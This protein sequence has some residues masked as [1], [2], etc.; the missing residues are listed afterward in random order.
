[1][2]AKKKKGKR[3]ELYLVDG[4]SSGAIE[5]D[6]VNSNFKLVSL[7]NDKIKDYHKDD[8]GRGFYLLVQ[9]NSNVDKPFSVYV[10]ESK[11]VL[12]RTVQHQAD[13]NKEFE[14]IILAYTSDDAL[15]TNLTQYI[16]EKLIKFC[17]EHPLVNCTNK[18]KG[19]AS[20]LK[21][22]DEDTCEEL[23]E[24]F[25]LVLSALGYYFI[26][27]WELEPHELK[28][29]YATMPVVTAPEIAEAPFVKILPTLESTDTEHETDFDFNQFPIFEYHFPSRKFT[30]RT[31]WVA[32]MKITGVDSFVL[33]KGSYVEGNEEYRF[34]NKY[35]DFS[36]NTFLNSKKMYF[37]PIE[38][39]DFLNDQKCYVTK[40]D[41]TYFAPS[42][43]I[44]IAQG[45]S[46]NGWI[47]WKTADGETL[48]EVN[49][50]LGDP[51][52]RNKG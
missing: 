26:Q 23:L 15:N 52:G 27:D 50:R 48:D 33:L 46:N 20:K 42:S 8:V 37:N 13:T 10:G 38:H 12:T 14:R 30:H 16:E 7:P 45:A 24:Q 11:N 40:L 49:A 6:I 29:R 9:Q 2:Q 47:T 4:D 41:L 19:Q 28:A 39:A 21:R 17:D 3:L 1:M 5:V 25:A 22:K 43:P 35:H 32:R 36:L 51:L 34:K 18:N 31:G 44:D